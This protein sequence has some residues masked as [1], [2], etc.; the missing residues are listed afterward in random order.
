M[1]RKLIF[2]SGI[3]TCFSRE[4]QL[5]DITGSRLSDLPPSDAVCIDCLRRFL[6]QTP[7]EILAGTL[8]HLENV[9][10]EDLATNLFGSYDEFLG[11]LS[12]A[13]LRKHLDELDARKQY[14]D[15]TFLRARE[16]THRFR[17]ALLQLFFE[18]NN[19]LSTLTKIYGV[20]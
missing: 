2:V 6:R 10:V 1:S 13:T 12:D 4:L 19:K 16:L 18:R 15:E 11:I 14:E 9:N 20:F 3:I 7:L 8:L 17:D 5:P